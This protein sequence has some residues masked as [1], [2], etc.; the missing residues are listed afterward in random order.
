MNYMFIC[1]GL[2]YGHTSE[3]KKNILNN[4]FS[5]ILEEQ[6]RVKK[7]KNKYLI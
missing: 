7:I 4:V 1:P 5:V 3:I 6:K 2:L